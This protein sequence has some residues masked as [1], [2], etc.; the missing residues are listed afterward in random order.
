MLGKGV[1]AHDFEVS[2]PG[3]WIKS[4]IQGSGV[5]QTD[6]DSALYHIDKPELMVQRRQLSPI[7]F[8]PGAVSDPASTAK[9]NSQANEKREYVAQHSDEVIEKANRGEFPTRTQFVEPVV[10]PDRKTPQPLSTRRLKKSTTS[11]RR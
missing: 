3:R 11:R 2:F 4:S 10:R 9:P 7:P 6:G 8:L 5:P 1:L